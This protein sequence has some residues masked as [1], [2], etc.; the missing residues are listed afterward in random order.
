[1]LRCQRKPQIVLADIDQV[2]EPLQKTEHNENVGKRSDGNARIAAFKAG[3]GTWRGPRT[4]GEIRD[5]DATSQTRVAD[6]LA[7]PLQCWFRLGRTHINHPY[8]TEKG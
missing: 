8:L 5:R 1:M 3:N 2:G 4:N 7:K 6:I